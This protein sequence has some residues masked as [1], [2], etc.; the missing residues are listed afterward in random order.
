MGEPPEF[1]HS[2]HLDKQMN[3]Y[4][5]QLWMGTVARH[6]ISPRTIHL[7]SPLIG[8]ALLCMRPEPR[9]KR[10]PLLSSVLWSVSA[11]C[12]QLHF[13]VSA[14]LLPDTQ[15]SWPPHDSMVC[16]K[17]AMHYFLYDLFPHSVDTES[18]NRLRS[19]PTRHKLSFSLTLISQTDSFIA[20]SCINS[21]RYPSLLSALKN[22]LFS[23]KYSF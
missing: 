18:C 15:V 10:P 19:R 22:C 4:H 17:E 8:A 13:A 11:L 21:Y 3:V 20:C 5:F 14:W 16:E 7:N 12:V 1:V 2:A 9:F 6:Q 23:K